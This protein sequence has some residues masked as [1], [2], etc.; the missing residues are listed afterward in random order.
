MQ[1]T[2]RQ[3]GVI[4]TSAFM[5]AACASGPRVYSSQKPEVDFSSY[6]TYGYV[7]DL[8]TDDPGAPTSLLTQ[9]LKAA[10]DREMTARGYQYVPDGGELLVN[11]YVETKEKLESRR[12]APAGPQIGLGYYYY[13]RGL[14]VAWRSYPDD[15]VSQYTEGTLNI[16]LADASRHELVWE[17]VAIGRVTEE[18]RRNVQAAI[19]TVV[20]QL[21]EKFPGGRAP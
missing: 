9:Y 7:A 15:E 1:A 8:G 10:V 17:G 18:A 5:I 19:D 13:R 21:F 12:V 20:P 14:Y 16:D 11:F 2:I 3:L 6:R 4:A